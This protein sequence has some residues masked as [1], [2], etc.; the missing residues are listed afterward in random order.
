VVVAVCRADPVGAK[1]F[2]WAFE[3][4]SDLIGTERVRIVANRVRG[5]DDAA[6]AD[7]L[8]RHVGKRPVAYLP[9]DRSLV[10]RALAAGTSVHAGASGSAFDHGLRALVT[11]FGGAVRSRGLLTRLAGRAAR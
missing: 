5:S 8:A 1:N 10:D 7:L 9:D 6:L 11:S 3:Q 4:L 2:I